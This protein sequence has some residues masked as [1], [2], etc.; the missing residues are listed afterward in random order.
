M[1][2]ID[3]LK[4]KFPID[5]PMPTKEQLKYAM[6]QLEESMFRFCCFVDMFNTYFEDYTK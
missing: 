2:N 1:T 6:N 5:K 4:K 3:E